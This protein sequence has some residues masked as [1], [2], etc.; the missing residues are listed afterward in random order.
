MKRFI[1][2]LCLFGLVAGIVPAAMAD[3]WR[4]KVLPLSKWN[5]LASTDSTTIALEWSD[6][7]T[8]TGDT[9][10]ILDL[11]THITPLIG[12]ADVDILRLHIVVSGADNAV[13]SAA[14]DTMELVSQWS[15][16]G[17]NW[18]SDAAVLAIGLSP[19]TAEAMTYNVG[20]S[21]AGF[22]ARWWRFIL[23][24]FDGSAQT[25]RQ[26]SVRPLITVAR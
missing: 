5:K 4:V 8:A 17:V 20:S 24:Q 3:N 12:V 13:N 18:K 22:G 23:T 7:I 19:N 11:A 25:S 14:G 2:A 9:T 1:V 10:E 15:F 16:D 26:I 21:E 6:G